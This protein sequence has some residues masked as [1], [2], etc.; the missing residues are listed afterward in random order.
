MSV[1][2]KNSFATDKAGMHKNNQ[3]T[4]HIQWQ[5]KN[6]KRTFQEYV[7]P[8]ISNVCVTRA[9]VLNWNTTLLSL[10]IFKG[11]GFF[12]LGNSPLTAAT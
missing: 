9:I 4:A 5:E 7:S 8:N 10:S 12:L 11:M 2:Y 3:F 1:D 6:T